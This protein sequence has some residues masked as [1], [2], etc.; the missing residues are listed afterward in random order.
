MRVILEFIFWILAFFIFWANIGYPLSIILIGKVTKK[1]NKKIKDYEPTVTLMIVAHN[2][3]KVIEKKLE[4]ALK[5]EYPKDKLEILVSSDNSTDKT[6]RIVKDFINKNK[7]YNIRLYTVKDRKGKT[8][9]QNEAAK[10]VKSEILVMTDANA[11]LKSD[12]IKELVSSFD[13][14]VVYVSGKL[15]YSNSEDNLTS[16]TENIYWNLDTRV[17]D[18]ESKIQTITAGNGAIYACRTSEY[19]DFDP[20]KS[21]DS[22]MPLHYALNGKRAIAN[23]NAIAY[24]KAG[25]KDA[26]EFERK[27]RMSR[28]I[29]SS[30][31]PSIKIL[32]FFKYKWFTYF[33]LGHR[34]LR[35]LLW[36]NHILLFIVNIFL[37]NYSYIYIISFIFQIIIYIMALLKQVFKINNKFV[38]FCSYYCMTVLA[39]FV[40]VYKTITKQ[41]KPFWEKVESTR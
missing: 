31:L 19:V 17:R 32:N 25:E 39:Q 27:V 38:N 26:D 7:K 21:H 23:H 11:I 37:L 36:L 6:D 18:I 12:S 41:N 16:N 8:N 5:L 3:E 35:Y 22:A 34:T 9:A 20:I 14:N 40:G 1:Q 13:N 15:V 28:D 24:E 4:N 29:L 30:I 33:Y 10:T 2:E